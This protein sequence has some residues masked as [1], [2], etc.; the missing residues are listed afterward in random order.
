MKQLRSIETVY[1][2]LG[3]GDL[4]AGDHIVAGLTGAR[5]KQAWFWRAQSGVFPAYVYRDIE[6]ALN[7][8][9]Y[10]ASQSLFAMRRVRRAA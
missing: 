4:Q 6:I 8:R 2:T 3:D 7:K 10:T 1:R 5:R 9:G